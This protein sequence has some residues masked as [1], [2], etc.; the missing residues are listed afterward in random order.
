MTTLE[1]VDP[2]NG[3]SEFN[4]RWS[5]NDDPYSDEY[6]SSDDDE[7]SDWNPLIEEW[8]IILVNSWYF[9]NLY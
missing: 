5:D 4:D 2:S 8:V 6:D 1:P 7:Y 9:S 3:L